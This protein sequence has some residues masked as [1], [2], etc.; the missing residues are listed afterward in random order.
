MLINTSK[1]CLNLICKKKKKLV[2]IQLFSKWNDKK[3]CWR[4][5]FLEKIDLLRKTNES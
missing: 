2:Y 1:D 4:K 5:S 3:I